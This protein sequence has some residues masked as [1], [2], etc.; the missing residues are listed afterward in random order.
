[1]RKIKV[2]FVCI[3]NSARSQMAEALLKKHGRDFFEVESAG[4]EPGKL[5]PL[6][7]K[8]MKDIGIDISQNQATSVFD[9]FRKGRNYNFVITVCDESSS[10]RCPIFPGRVKR[11]HWGFTDPAAL[12]GT[13]AEKQEQTNAIRDQIEQKIFEFIKDVLADFCDDC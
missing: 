4:L 8:A 7:V 5:N 13:E 2:L 3:H 1:M 9:L 6:A 11:L 10:E 12:S